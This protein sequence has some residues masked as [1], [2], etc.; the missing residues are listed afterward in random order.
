MNA[1]GGPMRPDSLPDDIDLLV[2][3]AGAAGLTAALVGTL[4]G[5]RV[6]LCEASQQVGGT[7]ATSAGTVWVPGNTPGREAGYGD[8]VAAAERY[9]QALAGADTDGARSAF[10]ARAPEAFDF[11]LAEGGIPFVP[12]ALHPDYL[13]APGAARSGRAMAPPPFDGR[14]LGRDFARVRAPLPSFMVLGS[15]MVGKDDV[16]RLLRRYASLRDFLYAARLAGRWA[17]DRLRYPRGTR[18]VMGNALVARLLHANL[19]RGTAVRYG[20]RASS[21]LRAQGRVCGAQFVLPDGTQA[22]V[23]AHRGVVLA[24]GG[25]GQ[26]A[27]WRRRLLGRLADIRSLVFEGNQGDGL[28]LAGELGG[29]VETAHH[30]PAAFWQPVSVMPQQR[31]REAL[32]PHLAM[33]RGKPGLIAVLPDGRRF[34]NEGASYHHFVEA[35]IAADPSGRTPAWLICTEGFV[36]RYGLGAIRPGTRSLDRHVRSG[37]LLREASVAALAR[38]AGIDAD[39]LDATLRSYNA[40]A[41][42]GEDPAFGKGHTVLSRF[43]GDAG[44]TPNPGLA[45]I[46]QGPFCAMQVWAADAASGAGLRTD[47]HARVLDAHGTP[48]EGL[49]AC[50]NDM[51]SVMGSA[52]PGP[53]ITLGPAMTF[54]YVAARHAAQAGG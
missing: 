14:L 19:A 10:L 34:V 27:A 29:A 25:F 15:M 44:H 17:V 39:A 47:A 45:P 13:E 11:L 31:G 36:R 51:A 33:D 48:I 6:L 46:E 12:A 41:R 9:L 42:Q 24:T 37:Y 21:L 22:R 49:Y 2:L 8:T 1:S 3:G 4:S 54:G 23:R 28:A 35:M 38:R 52:Y 30:A 5:L 32:F 53:G 40:H 16:Q 43:N 7:T 18:L 20:V 26:G 50:G